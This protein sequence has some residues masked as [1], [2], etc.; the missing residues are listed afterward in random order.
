[1]GGGAEEYEKL[2]EEKKNDVLTLVFTD[3]YITLMISINH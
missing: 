1:M 2:F 3:T